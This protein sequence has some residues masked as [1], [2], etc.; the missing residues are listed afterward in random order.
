[1]TARTVGSVS[2][3]VP[4]SYVLSVML[5]GQLHLLTR[6]VKKVPSTGPWQRTC[7]PC[8]T[9][10]GGKGRWLGENVCW[11]SKCALISLSS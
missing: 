8:L 2:S 6:Q 9:W 4:D 10:D 1:M 7:L 3:W 11:V 5:W